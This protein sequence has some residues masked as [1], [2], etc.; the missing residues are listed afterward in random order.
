MTEPMDEKYARVKI[1]QNILLK[2]TYKHFMW[3]VNKSLDSDMS[4]IESHYAKLYV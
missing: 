4:L 3:L 1:N 2:Y